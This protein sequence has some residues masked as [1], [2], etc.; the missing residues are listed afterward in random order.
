MRLN[1]E[2]PVNGTV[3]GKY[4]IDFHKFKFFTDLKGVDS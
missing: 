2:L 4:K 1:C 3:E